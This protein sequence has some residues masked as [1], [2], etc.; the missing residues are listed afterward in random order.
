M[1]VKER[2]RERQGRRGADGLCLGN[3]KGWLQLCSEQ[4][5]HRGQRNRHPGTQRTIGKLKY[6]VTGGNKLLDKNQS[7]RNKEILKNKEGQLLSWCWKITHERS[8]S[9]P[10]LKMNGR[11]KTY[12]TRKPFRQLVERG[13]VIQQTASTPLTHHGVLQPLFLSAV[14]LYVFRGALLLWLISGLP[15]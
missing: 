3:K 9:H 14:L 10:G 4:H 2:E 13:V 12:A 1:T 8:I 6:C 11:N 15:T 7:I 5:H